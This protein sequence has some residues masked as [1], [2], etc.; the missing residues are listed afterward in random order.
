MERE[1]KFFFSV[2]IFFILFQVSFVAAIQ[3][4]KLNY[5]GELK[6]STITWRTNT[7]NYHEQVFL[8]NHKLNNSIKEVDISDVDIFTIASGDLI[9]E[10]VFDTNLDF[11]SASGKGTISNPEY[12]YPIL[13]KL[14][15]K[16]F[17]IVGVGSN[18]IKVVTG[19]MGTVD[20]THGITYGDYTTYAVIGQS[21]AWATIIIRDNVGNTVEN[22][23]ITQGQ[24]KDS[25][26]TGLTIKVTKVSALSDGTV[27]GVKVIVGPMGNIEKTYTTTG[28]VFPSETNWK[29]QTNGFS[30]NAYVTVGDKIQ[31]IYKPAATQ[32]FTA[33]QTLTLANNYGNIVFTAKQD[34]CVAITCINSTKNCSDGYVASCSNTCTNG[35][36][37]QC[38][39]NC[40]GHEGLCATVTCSST[41]QICSD[42]YIASCQQ[43]CN[44]STGTCVSCIPDCSGHQLD[45]CV[46]VQC[47]TNQKTCLDG[48]IASCQQTCDSTTGIC[49]T[50]TPS[51]TGHEGEV[52]VCQSGCLQ[53]GA[54]LS[55]GMRI[56]KDDIP[57]YCDV[58][59][60][61]KTQKEDGENCLN[62][63]ECKTNYCSNNVCVN[64]QKEL[65][66]QRGILQKILDFLKGIFSFLGS[67][68]RV[69]N[70][71]NST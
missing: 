55:I 46:N 5:N 47:G 54:C 53:N 45:K 56:M 13:V 14:L 51:C 39:P 3:I 11:S 4:D 58:S 42:G 15:G 66:E 71:T 18:Q 67:F 33:G 60:S 37:S 59:N 30:S 62:N 27:I 32:S 12:T 41:T 28:D 70:S 40:I 31:V 23:T 22:T 48:Y 65:E 52:P 44:P 9:Y 36:C 49:L 68:V 26:I 35:I 2:I 50:C 38:T 69:Y 25:S 8:K 43:T 24:S 21:D 6:S 7:Y 10:Y 1:I 64:L 63:Y 34:M 20:S 19:L 17:N 29:I 57:S 16:D 61:I